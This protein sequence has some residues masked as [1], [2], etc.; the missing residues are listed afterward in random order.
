MGSKISNL[1]EAGSG[2]RSW[3]S[4]G[5]FSLQPSPA[6]PPS[7]PKGLPAPN[8]VLPA[9]NYNSMMEAKSFVFYFFVLC[10]H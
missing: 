2:Q 8:V 5:M 10:R 6:L 9:H 7:A 1:W 3:G 4:T